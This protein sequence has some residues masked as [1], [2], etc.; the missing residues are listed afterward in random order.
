MAF[1]CI[2]HRGSL[3]VVL[4]GQILFSRIVSCSLKNVVI[5]QHICVP[6]HLLVTALLHYSEWA[7][8]LCCTLEARINQ[9]SVSVSSKRD[10]QIDRESRVDQ[11]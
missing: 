5:L 7:L 6:L 10:I 1:V 2:E 4:K 9:Q 11:W 3:Q 8:Q